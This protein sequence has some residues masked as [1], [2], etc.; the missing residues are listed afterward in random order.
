MSKHSLEEDPSLSKQEKKRRK[1][2]KKD[3]KNALRLQD[4]TP[5][6]TDVTSTSTPVPEERDHK[7]DYKQHTDLNALPQGDIDNFYKTNAVQITDPQSSTSRPTTRPILDFSHL[8]TELAF[9][10]SS[11]FKSFSKPTP[12]QSAAWP[13]L[14]S[15]RDVV[16]I[17]QT[18]SGKTI[19]FGLP[20]VARL[21]ALKKSKSIRAVV[22]APTRELAIQV[23]TQISGLCSSTPLKAACIYGGTNKDSQRSELRGASIIIA[24]PGR[25]KDFLSDDTV[26]LSKVRYLVLDEA[27][28]MLDAGF[29]DDIKHIISHC[30]ATPKRQTAM[31]TATWPKSIR[32]LADTFMTSPIKITIG[33]DP[34]TSSAPDALRANPNVK[35][36]VHILTDHRQK[37]DLLLKLLRQQPKNERILIFA[38]YKKEAVRLTETLSRNRFSCTSIHGDLAQSQ[39]LANLNSFTTGKTPI[40]IAT[41][42]AAR[43]LDIPNINL[44]VNHTFPL[45]VEDYV[46]RI[47]RTGRAGKSGHAITYFTEHEKHLA[48]GLVNV[49]KGAGQV[50]PEDLLKFG[51]T[52]KKKT[53]SEYGAFFREEEEGAKKA[54]KITFDD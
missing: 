19:A 22:V 50:V 33:H 45:T 39:R 52:V 48:G 2:D 18:G 40:L 31:F 11:A 54:T 21:L 27:D 37:Q 14:L 9:N 20:L 42:V 44:V 29:S 41:D 36:T 1:Q 6:S 38:L 10:F 53:H 46:H 13:F 43:G 51:T 24:T 3:R 49:L 17:S 4:I 12:I 25:L 7:Q 32:D 35:Q 23:H 28:R 47:G 15:S 16:G 26:S 34:S 8:P 5:P 30:P